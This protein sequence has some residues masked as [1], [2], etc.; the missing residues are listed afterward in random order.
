M[1]QV[2]Q[3]PPAVR[4]PEVVA[5]AAAGPAEAGVGNAAIQAGLAPAA[6]ARSALLEEDD[7]DVSRREVKSR[8]R[9]TITNAPEPYGAWEDNF[10]WESKFELAVDPSAST[11][12]IGVRI[13]T[14]ATPDVRAKWEAAIEGKWGGRY[15]L[16]VA[17]KRPGEEAKRYRIDCD[18]QWVEKAR[19]AH[20]DVTANQA[21]SD[22][23]GRAGLGGTDSMTGWGTGD[24]VD[25]TH[26]FGH[27]LGAVEDY[28]TTN[29]QDNT[30]GGTRRGFRDQGGGVMN[31][32]S[33]DP[34]TQHY[35]LVR[36]N[37][38]RLLKVDEARCSVQ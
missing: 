20:Y 18:L 22:A 8:V 10:S 32:P 27:M 26:E 34:F 15:D 4:T 24:T 21:G 35:D 13:F 14:D 30:A 12:T 23:D 38:A 31:N 28:F 19:D 1:P 25:V 33:E 37:A 11:L 16:V 17:P 2:Q 36:S 3:R 7:S 9:E 5:P 6:P 29:G